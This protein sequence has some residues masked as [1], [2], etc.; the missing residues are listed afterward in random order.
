MSYQAQKNKGKGIYKINFQRRSHIRGS[1]LQ[2]FKSSRQTTC[3]I[4]CIS[5]KGIIVSQGFSSPHTLN[6]KFNFPIMF[7]KDS[8]YW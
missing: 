1:N 8:T 5:N 7:L 6:L 4:F 2:V 3:A